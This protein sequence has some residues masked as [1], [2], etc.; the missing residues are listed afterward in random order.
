MSLE[1]RSA[2]SGIDEFGVMSV[3]SIYSLFATLSRSNVVRSGVSDRL[4]EQFF[5]PI[6]GE[7][8]HV[9][10]LVEIIQDEEQ[11]SCLLTARSVL[12]TSLI[13]L[14]HGNL[15]T[16]KGFFDVDLSLFGDIQGVNKLNIIKNCLGLDIIQK[17]KNFILKISDLLLVLF[18]LLNLL[19]TLGLNFRLLRL[20]DN[21][22][23]LIFKTILLDLEVDHSDLG[24][25]FRSVMRVAVSS[26]DVELELRRPFN[27]FLSDL[28]V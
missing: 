10:D 18:N 12:V 3:D 24:R 2:N 15:G 23:A 28:N 13:N 14:L 8:I 20:D 7:L 19:T 6:E 5:V 4:G 25:Y 11:N 27:L 9:I 22:E 21:L 17:L 1:Q 26:G 16:L